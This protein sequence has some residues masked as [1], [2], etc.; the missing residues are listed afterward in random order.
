VAGAATMPLALF[1]KMWPRKLAVKWARVGKAAMGV[2]TRRG[3]T[4][5]I[6]INTAMCIQRIRIGLE[7]RH[8]GRSRQSKG[9][10]KW[11]AHT[12]KPSKKWS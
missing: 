5:C 1:G 8:G 10:K 11:C 3:E 12:R 7:R 9:S 6:G 4:S 2:T